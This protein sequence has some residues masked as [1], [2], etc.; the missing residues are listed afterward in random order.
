[1]YRAPRG[2]G[3]GGL[4]NN[5]FWKFPRIKTLRAK[6]NRNIHFAFG[7]EE[8]W[9]GTF[10][11]S[12]DT[13]LHASCHTTA[14]KTLAGADFDRR[15]FLDEVPKQKVPPELYSLH[16]WESRISFPRIS[17]ENRIGVFLTKL[18]L[19]LRY[20]TNFWSTAPR[21]ARPCALMA[22][23]FFARTPTFF[24]LLSSSIESF[25]R[26]QLC[27][28]PFYGYHEYPLAPSSLQMSCCRTCTTCTL[29]EH[30]AAVQQSIS[31]TVCD[32]ESMDFNTTFDGRKCDHTTRIPLCCK[33]PL[34]RTLGELPCLCSAQNPNM[35]VNLSVSRAVQAICAER[36]TSASN[37]GDG[38]GQKKARTADGGTFARLCVR[39]RRKV[40]RA[41]LKNILD[42]QRRSD[43]PSRFAPCTPHAW[44]CTRTRLQHP[45]SLRA[46]WLCNM[47]KY[48]ERCG[49]R[50]PVTIPGHDFWCKKQTISPVSQASQAASR[51]LTCSCW[52]TGHKTRTYLLKHR[53]KKKQ[54]RKLRDRQEKETAK[55][56]NIER[57]S[58]NQ[59]QRVA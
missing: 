57:C 3:G 45:R 50:G 46:T 27:K 14:C 42:I 6:P 58:G 33:T 38:D 4:Q 12:F 23:V 29:L 32:V 51:W 9:I 36:S 31:R 54:A 53:E 18:E 25:V 17:K 41:Q 20:S 30:R 56:A 34:E 37:D 59:V 2:G 43:K 49:D 47:C 11:V 26:R 13:H 8:N 28:S 48:A 22:G 15:H 7:Y 21:P 52:L 40:C 5:S 55:D 16:N 24:F 1:M 39:G 44:H 35:L 19:S 10:S